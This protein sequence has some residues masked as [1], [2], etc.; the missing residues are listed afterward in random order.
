VAAGPG[1]RLTLVTG[2]IERIHELEN[3]LGCFFDRNPDGTIHQKAFAGQTFDRT[4]HKG[5]PHRHRDHESPRR[6][7]VGARHSSPGRASRAD[8]VAA[9]TECLPACPG[10]HPHGDYVFVQA[11]AALLA[12]GGGPTMYRYHTRRA[13]RAATARDGLRRPLARHGD[14]AVPSDRPPR[15]PAHAHDRH[16][17]GEALRGAGGYLTDG[18]GQR[19]MERYDPRGERATRDIVSRAIHAEMAGRTTPNGGVYLSMAI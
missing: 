11:K 6:T 10:R 7:G 15:R 18:D 4:V 8:F 9:L 3:E 13:T 16:R 12:T 5:R 14:G 2:A 1:P 19:F 17:A